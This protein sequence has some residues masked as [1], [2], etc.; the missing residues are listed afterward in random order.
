MSTTKWKRKID[1]VQTGLHPPISMLLSTIRSPCARSKCPGSLGRILR[2]P[3]CPTSS[4]QQFVDGPDRHWG[5]PP[6]SLLSFFSTR[7]SHLDPHR[8]STY[9]LGFAMWPRGLHY[10]SSPSLQP[11]GDH[12]IGIHFIVQSLGPAPDQ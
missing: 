7:Q 3:R 12:I 5:A 1:R 9:H 2:S 4:D 11:I 10:G 6:P 8:S